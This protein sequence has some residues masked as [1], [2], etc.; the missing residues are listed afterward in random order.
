MS[1][2]IPF[3]FVDV[4][5]RTCSNCQSTSADVEV[6]RETWPDRIEDFW[7]CPGCGW[8]NWAEVLAE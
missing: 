4:T 5:E 1:T 3:D 6:H 8:E 7:R 2:C